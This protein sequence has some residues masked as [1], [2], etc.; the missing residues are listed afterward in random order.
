MGPTIS[1]NLPSTGDSDIFQS[2]L[3]RERLGRRQT[4][5]GLDEARGRLNTEVSEPGLKADRV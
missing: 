3:S 5:F 4:F 2:S 1:S